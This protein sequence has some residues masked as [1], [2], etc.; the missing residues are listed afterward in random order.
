M[1]MKY[2]FS[3]ILN[4]EIYEKNHV[5]GVFGK[6]SFFN[7]IACDK[8]RDTFKNS[9]DSVEST[10][11]LV[12]VADEFGI[13]PDTDTT[14]TAVDFNTFMEVIGV[15]SINGKWF[16]KVDIESLTKKQ[17]ATLF[18]YIKEPSENGKLV[19]V[20][21]DWLNYKDFLRNKILNYSNVVSYIQ[22]NFPSR[23][24]LKDIVKLLFGEH[25]ITIDNHSIELFITR[26]GASYDEYENMVNTIEELHG[27]GDLT[28]SD[29]RTY[30]KGIEN[31]VIDD[32]I[33]ELVKPISSDK[34]NNKK[35][36][37]MMTALEDELTAKGLIYKVLKVINEAIEFRVLINAGIIP[38]GI[39]YFY[40]DTIADITKLYGEDNKFKDMH[41]WVFRRK[42]E[43]ASRTSI[44]DWEY[45]QLILVKALDQNFISDVEMD[46]RCKRALYD[47][48]TRSVL[49]ESRLNNIIGID[50]ILNKQL[51]NLDSMHIL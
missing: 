16:C 9:L 47:I 17:L 50:N 36:L 10:L 37:R 14:S 38:I 11:Q 4:T 33:Y 30:M 51:E 3:D 25:G 44:R 19:L 39:K 8:I 48:C 46:E 7:N 12:G 43:L 5:F 35:I 22:L 24:A 40:K 20:A 15:P 6:Y 18:K 41:E 49:T 13:E 32:F 1:K 34:T 29:L 21:T 45:M 2:N 27:H 31:F 23:D 26:M 28:I 42:A